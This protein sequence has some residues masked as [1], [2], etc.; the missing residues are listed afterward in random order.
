MIAAG[1]TYAIYKPQ[2]KPILREDTEYFNFEGKEYKIYNPHDVFSEVKTR[3]FKDM[4][5]NG[6]IPDDSSLNKINS[7]SIKRD[8]NGDLSM[9]RYNVHYSSGN[10]NKGCIKY[11]LTR[12]LKVSYELWKYNRRGQMENI[13]GINCVFTEKLSD[14]QI[15]SITESIEQY[16]FRLKFGDKHKLLLIR[17]VDKENMFHFDSLHLD[18]E[19]CE[20]LRCPLEIK[21]IK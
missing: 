8:Y 14:E 11:G 21:N 10:F 15:K 4:K 18:G 12:K 7:V 9:Y 19:F 20:D 1:I 16:P 6:Y 17:G 13:N 5:K 3:V 2:P